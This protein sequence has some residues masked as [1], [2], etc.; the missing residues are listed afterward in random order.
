M[1]WR[2]HLPWKIKLETLK[3]SSSIDRG[4]RGKWEGRNKK[5]A[6]SGTRA[7]LGCGGGG[8]KNDFKK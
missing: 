1:H 3:G 7:I 4:I 5:T 6:F 8:S 2:I